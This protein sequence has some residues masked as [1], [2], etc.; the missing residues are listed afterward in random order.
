MDFETRKL[1]IENATGPDE[2]LEKWRI[3]K[4]N[5]FHFDNP[6]IPGRD[7][8]FATHGYPCC[9]FSMNFCLIS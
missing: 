6:S 2:Y 3:D 8:S 5:M 7:G 1:Q 9:A 4:A